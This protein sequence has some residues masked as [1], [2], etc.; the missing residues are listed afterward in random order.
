M[1]LASE[2]LE[3]IE[4]PRGAHSKGT[5]LLLRWCKPDGDQARPTVG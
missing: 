5:G 4:Q 1:N 2:V 3:G